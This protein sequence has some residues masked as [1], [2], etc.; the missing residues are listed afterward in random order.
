MD[1]LKQMGNQM[2]TTPEPQ[3]GRSGQIPTESAN[4]DQQLM[5][6]VPP[7]SSDVQLNPTE[8]N[9]N[10]MPPLDQPVQGSS[11]PTDDWQNMAGQMATLMAQ[12]KGKIP[13]NDAIN[14]PMGSDLRYSPQ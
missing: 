4:E 9:A 5:M 8:A 11:L 13:V 2:M 14:A 10:N 1:L 6:G 7:G 12:M 3:Q